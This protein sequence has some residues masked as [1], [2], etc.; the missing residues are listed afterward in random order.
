MEVQPGIRSIF[1]TVSVMLTDRDLNVYVSTTLG[2]LQHNGNKIE[3]VKIQTQVFSCM[4]MRKS[5]EGWT[6]A[7]K[8]SSC[9]G[10][11]RLLGP[12]SCLLLCQLSS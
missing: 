5:V 2:L 4:Q 8:V 1:I 12:S 6:K 11:W 3:K 9:L 10:C 7:T